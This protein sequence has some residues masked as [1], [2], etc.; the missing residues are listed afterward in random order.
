MTEVR[1]QIE[2]LELSDY[3]IYKEAMYE[4]K[5]FTGIAVEDDN[6]IHTEWSFVNGNGHG[7]WFSVYHDGQLFEETILEYGKVISERTWNKKGQLIHKLDSDP[8]LD[9]DFDDKGNLLKEKTDDHFWVF[10]DNGVK[11]SDYDYASSSVTEF[12]RSGAWIVKG[13]LTDGYLVLSRENIE[14]NDEYWIENYISILKN[15]YE[16]FYPYFRIWLKDKSY[17]R[18]EIICAMIENTDLRLKYDGLLLAREYVVRDAISLIEK[19][20]TIKKCP[21]ATK[22]TSYGFS[23]GSLAKQVLRD[24]K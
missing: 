21:P 4:D 6:G 15:D 18:T 17:L 23:V 1:V 10:F 5:P 13:R 14:F 3:D 11:K 7:R 20:I 9:Q 24:L 8:L 12:D 19:Q 2:D 22:S 16:E